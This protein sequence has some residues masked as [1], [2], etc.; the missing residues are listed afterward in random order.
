M[1]TPEA[2]GVFPRTMTQK[3]DFLLLAD[4]L[5]TQGRAQAFID[6][7]DADAASLGPAAGGRSFSFVRIA[8]DRTRIF[9]VASFAG[10]IAWDAGLT[11]PASQQFHKTSQDLSGEQMQSADGD[12]IFYSVQGAKSEADAVL[13]AS[14]AGPLWQSLSG[15]R[16]GHAIVVDD[17][18]WYLNAGP[19]AARS[20]LAGLRGPSLPHE[21]RAVSVITVGPVAGMSGRHKRDP[22]IDVMTDSRHRTGLGH[23]SRG[24]PAPLAEA[25]KRSRHLS[26]HHV[27]RASRGHVGPH[28]SRSCGSRRSSMST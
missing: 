17:D 9:G 18:P 4:S 23:E 25:S 10:F 7:F 2:D 11:R 22:I 27:A 13:A 12:W 3:Q 20:V 14:A 21:P 8:A 26:N 5:G 6:D 1:G 24:R 15:V 19:T 16:N 28:S